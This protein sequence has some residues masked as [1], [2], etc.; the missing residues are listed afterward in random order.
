[1]LDEGDLEIEIINNGA[2]TDLYRNPDYV[3]L[4]RY[5]NP[6]RP[7]NEEREGIVSKRE[8]IGGWYTDSFADLSAYTRTRI[9]GQRGGRFV[10]VRIKKEDLDKYDATKLPETRDMDIESGNYMIPPSVGINSR[11]E[12][13]GIFKDSWEGK[14]NIPLSEWKE[15]GEYIQNNLSDEAIIS[16]LKGR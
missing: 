8:L 15:I 10:V 4:Y 6:T 2:K 5:E 1:M 7:Y 9:K 12:V 16:Q 11:V 3:S 14:R 13:S